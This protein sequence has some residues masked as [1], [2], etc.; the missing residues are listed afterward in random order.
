M[1]GDKEAEYAFVVGCRRSDFADC[2]G[3]RAD[4]DV[5][6]DVGDGALY[7]VVTRAEDEI[8]AFEREIARDGIGGIDAQ[9]VEGNRD[10][11]RSIGDEFDV[12]VSV[13]EI[14]VISPISI[15]D[16]FD[17]ARAFGF[18]RGERDG[19]AAERRRV[20]FGVDDATDGS[21]WRD[22]D[23]LECF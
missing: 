1:L 7:V 21:L 6:S 13:I 16:D 2:P 22:V 15:G 3:F 5:G 4:V 14:D 12:V 17:R 10:A 11:T 8:G 20:V 23:I 19:H 9:C 18:E